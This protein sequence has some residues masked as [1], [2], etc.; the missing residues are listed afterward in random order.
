MPRALHGLRYARKGA[1]DLIR[2]VSDDLHTLD[3]DETIAFYNAFNEWSGRTMQDV[4]F[5]G[6]NDRFFLLSALLNRRDVLHPWLFARCREVEREPDNCLDLWAR[7]HYKSSI[8]TFGG[9]IQEIIRDPEITIS[10]FSHTRGIAT[11]FL[12][13]IKR[14]L[15]QN[16]GLKHIYPDVFWS[17]PEVQAPRWSLHDGIICIRKGNPKE[18]TIEAWGLVDG[19]PTSKHFR[20]MI[21]DDVVTKD[22]V[23]TP[24]MVK[25]TTDAWELSDNL[26]VGEATRKWHIGTRYSFADTYNDIMERKL[27]KERKYAAT[28]NG[29]LDGDPVFMTP[30]EWARVKRTQR[31]TVAAQMLQNPAAGSQASFDM[32]WAK[33]YYFRPTILNVYILVDPSGGKKKNSDRTAMA[34]IGVDV[35][36]NKYLLDGYRHRMKLSERWDR[37]RDLYKKWSKAQGVQAVYVGYEKYGMQADIEYFQQRM[38]D[39]KVEFPIAEVNWVQGGVGDQAKISRINRLQP[40]ME[41]G[42]EKGADYKFFFP[43]FVYKEGEGVCFWSFNE[44]TGVME[45]TIAEEEQIIRATN[46]KIKVIRPG[47]LLYTRDQKVIMRNHQPWRIAQPI[48]A[49]E[50]F[51]KEKTVYDLTRAFFEEMAL[52]PFGQ[53][54]DL[55]DATSRLYDM[56]YT[57]PVP[58]ESETVRNAPAFAD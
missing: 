39:E 26:G 55:L 15:E 19:Q 8:I 30:S 52:F 23:T 38:I 32:A 3:F 13:Q 54:D 45:Y 28:R 25:K 43:C 10:I 44:D 4:A 12:D 58:F 50:T 18:A 47:N 31:S 57:A 2:F 34:V 1:E 36:K 22:N 9:S 27:F 29:R 41:G 51:G 56:N 14:E 35:V 48:K 24:E 6:A 53:K 11:G 7:Y 37:L 21:Y 17:R 46:G 42:G 20:L 5:L 40:D 33:P 49:M 16:D